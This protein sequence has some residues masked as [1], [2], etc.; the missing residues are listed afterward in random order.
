MSLF[1]FYFHKNIKSFKIFINWYIIL[2]Y[3]SVTY[4]GTGLHNLSKIKNEI[5]EAI[6][7]LNQIFLFISVTNNSLKMLF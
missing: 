2:F 6:L 4:H 3:V 5:T 7:F 1:M